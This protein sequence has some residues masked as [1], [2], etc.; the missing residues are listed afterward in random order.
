MNEEELALSVA[1]EFLQGT[2]GGKSLKGF[3]DFLQ[4]RRRQMGVGMVKEDVVAKVHTE[5]WA[6]CNQTG[7]M[8]ED[9]QGGGDSQLRMMLNAGAPLR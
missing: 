8:K 4:R 6:E 5:G 2:V 1:G 9:N 3:Q 7:H